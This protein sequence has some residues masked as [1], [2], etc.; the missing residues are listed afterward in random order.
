MNLAVRGY[1]GAIILG[2]SAVFFVMAPRVHANTF[3]EVV[4]GCTKLAGRC[5][6]IRTGPGTEYPAV[7]KARIG[8]VFEV[9]GQVE[10]GGLLW[11]RVKKETSIRYPERAPGTWY[12][13][14]FTVRVTDEPAAEYSQTPKRTGKY[15]VVDIS[16]QKLYAYSGKKIALVASV[17]T[18]L[19]DSPTPKGVFHIYKKQPSRYMQGPLPGVSTQEYDLPGVPWTM[20]FTKQGGAIHGAYWHNSFGRPHS[21]GCVNLPVATAAWLYDWAPAGTPVIV[22]K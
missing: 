9:D 17:S 2:L 19:K 16:S 12:I 8:T 3:A 7:K 15:I 11:Y 20:Y 21:H 1:R 5:V 14:A 4:H 18:G 10:A 13:A 6:N 22:R